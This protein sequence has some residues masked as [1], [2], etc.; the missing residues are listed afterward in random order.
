MTTFDSSVLPPDLDEVELLLYRPVWRSVIA[1]TGLLA[2]LALGISLLVSDLIL[3]P[4]QRVQFT[5]VLSLIP[6]GAWMLFSWRNERRVQYPR[7][8]MGKLLLLSMLV[9]NAI[10]APLIEV[11]I[12]PADWLNGISGID[13]LIGYAL[14]VG[15]VSEFLK[16]MVLRYVVWPGQ[17]RR[18]LDSVAYSR[19]V[20]LGFAT[21]FN[22][23]FALFEGGAQPGP[24]VIR[25]VSVVL[26]HQAAGLV[27]SYALMNLKLGK[28]R[29]FG[30]ALNLVL[31]ALLHGVYHMVRAGM[32]VRGFG[33]GSAANAPLFGLIFSVVFAVILFGLHAF[34]IN[35]EDTRERRRQTTGELLE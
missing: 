10:A 4:N 22:L 13:R 9:A 23:R 30:L 3:T 33:I 29:T 7:R 27:V 32:V 24:A 6:I 5:A 17:Y 18:R 2:G 1:E 11:Y 16:Y 26:L 20:S 25:I 28:G 21:V 12:A 35:N 34:L 8:D 15:M 14:T 31:G 19:V